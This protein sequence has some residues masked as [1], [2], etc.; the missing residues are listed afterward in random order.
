MES[1]IDFV[2]NARRWAPLEFLIPENYIHLDIYTNCCNWLQSST[3]WLFPMTNVSKRYCWSRSKTQM[4]WMKRH[5]VWRSMLATWSRVLQLEQFRPFKM[6]PVL[7]PLMLGKQ[8]SKSDAVALS[9]SCI[10]RVC[11]ISTTTSF[12]LISLVLIQIAQ[13]GSSKCWCTVQRQCQCGCIYFSAVGLHYLGEE[14]L[15]F[16]ALED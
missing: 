9:P 15:G 11:K 16:W 13:K 6:L 12:A 5:L 8:L 4:W 14:F 7:W 10:S 3:N 2:C 1:I